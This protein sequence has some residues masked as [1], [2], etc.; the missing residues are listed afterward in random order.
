M[1]ER[2]GLEGFR[3]LLYIPEPLGKYGSLGGYE[4]NGVNRMVIPGGRI[5]VMMKMAVVMVVMGYRV[6]GLSYDAMEEY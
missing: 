6:R 5:V 4:M 3:I 2:R 1:G